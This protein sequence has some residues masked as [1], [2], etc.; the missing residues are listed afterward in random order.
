MSFGILS[1]SCFWQFVCP[2][3]LS[4][5]M[6]S[7]FIVPIKVQQQQLKVITDNFIIWL[8]SRAPKTSSSI[9]STT[10]KSIFKPSIVNNI[11]CQN[12]RLSIT[13][14]AKKR[15]NPQ[16]HQSS[17]LCFRGKSWCFWSR[18]FKSRCFRS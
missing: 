7:D 3:P 8:M 11:N 4:W 18:C 1:K 2:L 6:S 13:S 15:V 10:K 14:I 12:D 5:L 16:K 17:W 9:T